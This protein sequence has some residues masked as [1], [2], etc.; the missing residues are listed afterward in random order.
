MFGFNEIPLS[1][2]EEEFPLAYAA[3]VYKWTDE[4]H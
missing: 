4:V 2:E 1:K 3:L